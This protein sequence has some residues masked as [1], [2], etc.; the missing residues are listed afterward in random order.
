MRCSG[1]GKD[2]PVTG[3]VCP[4]CQR[5]KSTDQTQH[6]LITICVL[7]CVG[8]GY[9][10]G[11]F[12]GLLWG[13]GVGIVLGVIVALSA[14][15]GVASKPPQVRVVEPNEPGPAPLAESTSKKRLA[16]L[17]ALRKDGLISESEFT[18]KRQRILDEL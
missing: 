11:G 7:G 1:C 3:Q 6:T 10:V 9:F 12:S 16:D 15:S 8:V 2:I 14:G 17:E 18:A 4:Y 13:A 5:D